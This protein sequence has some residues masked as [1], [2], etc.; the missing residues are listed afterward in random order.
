MAEEHARVNHR[1]RRIRETAPAAETT[2]EIN[3]REHDAATLNRV[4]VVAVDEDVAAGGPHVMI[5]HPIPVLMPWRPISRAPCVAVLLPNPTPWQPNIAGGSRGNVRTDLDRRRRRGQIVNLAGL[6]VGPVSGSPLSTL[7]GLTPIPR[8]P[9]ATWRQGAPDAA[10]PQE[11]FALVLPTPVAG[12]PGHVGSHRP[13]VRCELLDWV[14]RRIG[15]HD[16]RLWIERD[17]LGKC[18]V[19]RPA[20]EDFHAVLAGGRRLLR[21]NVLVQSNRRA[22]GHQCGEQARSG[23]V[24]CVH[25][26]YPWLLRFIKTARHSPMP[27][28][29]HLGAHSVGVAAGSDVVG[30]TCTASA[31][32]LSWSNVWLVVT[33]L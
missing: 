10:D 30:A 8:H 1:R 26:L 33:L 18:F 13:L 29:P 12:N 27:R 28:L 3:G 4:V 22:S 31:F 17:C 21:G 5:W 23:N 7:L 24:K 2:T 9:L 32:D 19:Q 15:G 20:R 14:R 25:R 11:L 6:G 16:A